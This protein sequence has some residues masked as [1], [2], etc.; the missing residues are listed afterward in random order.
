MYPSL[1]WPTSTRRSCQRPGLHRV[2]GA[3]QGA[4]VPQRI[5]PASMSPGRVTFHPWRV[6]GDDRPPVADVAIGLHGEER[7]EVAFVDE[8]LG[9]ARHLPLDEAEMD[10]K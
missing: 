3:N 8:H 7:I 10:E 5:G 2:D 1:F 9:I 6:V 4:D